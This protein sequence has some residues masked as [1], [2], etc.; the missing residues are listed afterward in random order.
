MKQRIAILITC[1]SI[2]ML[3]IYGIDV[4]VNYTLN[5]SFLPFDHMIRGIVFGIPSII[6]PLFSF[7]ITKNIVT[8][9]LG[10]LFLIN[11]SLI[12]L[13]GIVVIFP[14]NT[15]KIVE[16]RTYIESIF[17]IGIGA[18]IIVLGINKIKK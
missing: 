1:I 18:L 11:G 3:V 2:F 10:I 5:A 14:N 17:L 9:N 7:L 15:E 16:F 12:I 8:R 4:L 13:G 6:L